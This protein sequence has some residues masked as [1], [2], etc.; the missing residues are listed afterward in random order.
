M[1]IENYE[2][3]RKKTRILRLEDFTTKRELLS[4]TMTHFFHLN[5]AMHLS[6]SPIHSHSKIIKTNIILQEL[7]NGV[8]FSWICSLKVCRQ[9]QWFPPY[10]RFCFPQ[11]Q[12]FVV[13]RDLEADGFSFDLS[14]DVN[15]S[16]MLGHKAYVIHLTSSHHWA[17]YHLTTS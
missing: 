7:I 4:N 13:N 15:C 5:P 3:C 11:F 16:L 6:T 10:A 14:S 17:F 9:F 1:Q 2:L 12:S 8:P